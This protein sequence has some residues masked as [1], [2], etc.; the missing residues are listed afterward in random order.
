MAPVSI[1]WPHRE[2]CMPDND[3]RRTAELI[4]SS[5]CAFVVITTDVQT[6]VGLLIDRQYLSIV[7]TRIRDI[8][9]S[10]TSLSP[11]A[12]RGFGHIL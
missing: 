6:A 1:T 12:G 8:E 2:I 7:F 9:A 10:E 11:T 4:H 5:L 3:A